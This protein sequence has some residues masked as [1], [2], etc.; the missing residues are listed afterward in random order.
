MKNTPTPPNAFALYNGIQISSP[1]PDLGEAGL[2]VGPNA[3]NPY[4]MLHGG[5]YYTLADCACGSACRT[6]GRRYVTLHGEIDYIRSGRS[7][8]VTARASVRHRGR[9]T[10]LTTADILD[11]DGTLRA[12]GTVPLFCHAPATKH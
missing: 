9:T 7:G 5:V 4:G 11:E 6:D 8:H 3:L 10:C 2:E 1:G 12:S